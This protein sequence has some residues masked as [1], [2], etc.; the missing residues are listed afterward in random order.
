M[1]YVKR[2]RFLLVLFLIGIVLVA[3]AARATTLVR[4]PFQ[5]LVQ[6]SSA[7]ARVRWSAR[8]EEAPPAASGGSSGRSPGAGGRPR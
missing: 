8:P 4:L 5:Q 6:Y 1:S 3:I 2:R 7:I